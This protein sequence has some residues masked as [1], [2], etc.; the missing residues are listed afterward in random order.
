[1]A[2]H[3]GTVYI[4]VRP[5]MKGF[6]SQ[7]E[8][9]IRKL[10]NVVVPVDADTEKFERKVREAAKDT[11]ASISVDTELEEGSLKAKA[12][13]AA[14][15]A[16]ST[17]RF[18]TRLDPTGVLRDA[19]LT[20]KG[21]QNLLSQ[22][23]WKFSIDSLSMRKAFEDT[24]LFT[25]LVRVQ[26]PRIKT[27]FRETGAAMQ[28][29]V[30]LGS[31]SDRVDFGLRRMTAGL[32]KIPGHLREASRAFVF[33][34]ASRAT[35]LVTKEVYSLRGALRSLGNGFKHAGAGSAHFFRSLGQVAGLKAVRRSLGDILSKAAAT[36][37]PMKAF[38]NAARGAVSHTAA[39]ATA[40]GATVVSSLAVQG[41][42]V[43]IGGV[44]G[45]VV[46]GLKQMSGIGMLIPGI[47]G[48]VG[49]AGATLFAGF[50]GL[51]GALAAAVD[52]AED[53]SE[54]LD[55]LAP[56]AA[57]FARAVED[58]SPAWRDVAKQVQGRMF[59]GLG[60]DLK[61]ISQVHLKSVTKGMSKLGDSFN[62]SFKW[63]AR[64]ASS[65]RTVDA[66]SQ[67]FDSMSR[68]V[69][70]AG[71]AFS[72]LLFALQDMGNVG[73][74]ALAD[75]S[76]AWDGYA[77]RLANW[78]HTEEA[79]KKMR[80][81]IDDSVEGFKDLG[82]TVG[83]LYET[84][85]QI[86]NAFGVDFDSSA[87]LAFREA[88]DDFREWIGL[89]DD[90]NS[91][92]SK[93]SATVRSF[94]APWIETFKTA[95]N[96]L[97]PAFREL[98]PLLED[99]SSKFAEGLGKTIERVAP[100]LEWFF[101]FLSD[102][103]EV[104]GTIAAALLKLRVAFGV[105][106]LARVLLSPF[107]SALGGVLGL[108]LRIKRLPNTVSNAVGKMKGKVSGW[109]DKRAARKAAREERKAAR[110]AKKQAGGGGWLSI[111]RSAKKAEKETGKSAKK[112][113]KH[114]KDV[115]KAGK[116]ERVTNGLF[117][118]GFGYQTAGKHAEKFS[119]KTGGKK[120]YSGLGTMTVAQ[121]RAQ[122]ST[123]DM[124]TAMKDS[125][126][127][128]NK[129]AKAT[130]TAGK[131]G[132]FSKLSAG[133]SKV[134]DVAPKAGK[135]LGAVGKGALTVGKFA[136]GGALRFIPFVGQLMLVH[137]AVRLLM[138]LFPKFGSLVTKVFS[139]IGPKIGEA[140]SKIGPKIGEI[141]SGIGGKLGGLFSG[142]WG[143]LSG[144]FSGIGPKIGAAFSSAGTWLVNAGSAIWN[145][146]KTG[147][148]TGWQAISGVFTGVK[149]KVLGAFGT[150]GMWL[151]EKGSAIWS[152]FRQG[153]ATGFSAVTG[154][155]ASVPGRIMSFFGSAGSWLLGKGIAVIQGLA[156]GVRSG[157]GL[158]ISAAASVRNSI[159][160]FF[161]GAF[162]W[163]VSA[164]SAL[165][166]GLASG[167]RGAIGA[168]TGAIS[169]VKSSI[170]GFFSGA[171]S[172]LVASGK[173][174]VQGFINGIRSMIDAAGAAAKA[175]VDKVRGF[176]PFSPAKEGPLSGK[177]YTTYSG[178][179]LVKDFAKGIRSEKRTA[180]SAAGD[181]VGAV[182]RQ[183]SG[184]MANPSASFEQYHRRAVLD[185]VLESN[186]A[187]IAKWRKDQAKEDKKLAS[188]IEKIQASKKSAADKEKAIAKA[189]QDAA[190]RN[191]ESYKQMVDGLE[192]PDYSEIPRS[193]R[194]Y[195]IEGFSGMIQDAINDS[196]KSSRLAE[197][198]RDAALGAV[199]QGR[200]V[201]GNHP[202]FEVI[203]RSVTAKHFEKAIISAIE[204]AGIAEV[205]VTF[206]AENLDQLKSDLGMGDGVVSRLIDAAID[207]DPTETDS[208]RHKTE[209]HY[210]VADMNEAIRLEKLR[211]R[212]QMMRM[213]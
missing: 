176:F 27:L 190:K 182:A 44:L 202:M 51:G 147:L 197:R 132:K 73:L 126:R 86:G 62:D 113:G 117:G 59:K 185:P 87:L 10:R 177:G 111:S 74:R 53:L 3:V 4:K 154:F 38:A 61:E 42:I 11:D 60:D 48:G 138:F 15:A 153:V 137:D 40:M 106:K 161:A 201:F 112:I 43:G 54:H 175:V 171:A 105:F 160:S 32:E 37:T 134:K 94:T 46:D 120:L 204:D 203:E 141:F 188:Q 24:G 52:P 76:E 22:K 63:F 189:H 212:K 41:A 211:E 151:V 165:L 96:E 148:S 89:A 6:R 142:I 107:I 71:S 124:S 23:P 66:V 144:F 31:F 178:Q 184:K 157:I 145:G 131:G 139:K 169:S 103:K 149:D 135:G 170:S 193:I 155:F 16:G 198:Y 163:L 181:V 72:P 209:V 194:G 102:N 17:V 143:K 93:F 128:M 172:W 167:V 200:R 133:L 97:I 99:V 39:V 67:G 187:T 150:A 26:F 69:S 191:K 65:R 180:A 88:T 179:A 115:G 186:A 75:M 123:R 8:R 210:H 7:I 183:F 207:F 146:L 91:R 100:K 33:G 174:L 199:K 192:K 84:F 206:V 98:R 58:I 109:S 57:D 158:A 35:G 34:T 64:F 30:V 83:N 173:A 140:F 208:K 13:A 78:T 108:L 129:S 130:K 70:N 79:Q 5:E 77:V 205:P 85:K 90:A 28:R 25:D 118:M 125:S 168:V 12:K 101:K 136:A 9:E 164:G 56:S 80:K 19:F 122:K 55:G 110:E 20:S 95:W 82:K 18:R 81:W 14:K 50:R 104:F 121:K 127:E 119:K 196:I 45:Y 213:K 162:S 152:G 47:L 156:N 92:I 159:V 29:L 68:I 166:N 2:E 1:M 195:Y 114:A 21:I 36:A 116:F 49:F